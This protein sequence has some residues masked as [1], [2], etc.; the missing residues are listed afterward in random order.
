MQ[1]NLKI[2]KMD[3]YTKFGDMGPLGRFNRESFGYFMFPRL[4]GEIAPHMM[5]MGKNV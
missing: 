5:F 3:I 2:S 1:P 4:E